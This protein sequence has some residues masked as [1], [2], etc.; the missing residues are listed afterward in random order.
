MRKAIDKGR[1]GQPV[2]SLKQN[3][4]WCPESKFTAAPSQGGGVSPSP[5]SVA[6]SWGGAT[7]DFGASRSISDDNWLIRH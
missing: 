5:D 4:R 6:A 2:V 3:A 1:A 7:S